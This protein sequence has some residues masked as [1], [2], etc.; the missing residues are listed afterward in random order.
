MCPNT[1]T[2]H[3]RHGVLSRKDALT[4][5]SVFVVIE[6]SGSCITT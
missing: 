1:L 3:I 2:R 4:A 5:E 6:R